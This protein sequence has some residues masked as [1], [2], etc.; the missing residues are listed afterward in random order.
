MVAIKGGCRRRE[1]AMHFQLGAKKTKSC[2]MENTEGLQ[3][4]R[5][6]EVN[7]KEST[8]KILVNHLSMIQ[9]K[10]QKERKN[11]SHRKVGSYM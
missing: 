7:F 6:R 3:T 1:R 9:P 10:G 4:D 5:V 2:M 8:L 11:K